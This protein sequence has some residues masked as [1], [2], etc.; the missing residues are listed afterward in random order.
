MQITRNVHLHVGRSWEGTHHKV[1]FQR[2]GFFEVARDFRRLFP[3]TTVFHSEKIYGVFEVPPLRDKTGGA[4]MAARPVCYHR[5]RSAGGTLVVPSS[6]AAAAAPRPV[7]RGFLHAL[8]F[9]KS[10]FP[11]AF[12]LPLSFLEGHLFTCDSG[13]GV[14]GGI[15]GEGDLAG[16]DGGVSEAKGRGGVTGKGEE[17]KDGGAP[18]ARA[19]SAFPSMPGYTDN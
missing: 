16:R 11:I 12:P 8:L 14:G 9:R 7:F 6:P 2:A 17:G 18:L 5:P 15:T 19:V 1:L 13:D 4:A 10:G 3:K